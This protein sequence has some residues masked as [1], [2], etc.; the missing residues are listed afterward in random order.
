MANN[1]AGYLIGQSKNGVLSKLPLEYIELGS[2]DSTPNQREEIKAERDDNTRDLI[3]V[4]AGGRKSAIHFKT[5]PNLTL[6]EKIAFTTWFTSRESNTDERKIN[7]TFWND[8]ENAYKTGDFYRPNMKFPILR[9]EE[10]T[11][12]I[13]YD[14]LEIDLI[15]Y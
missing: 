15:E 5:R 10:S 6:D 7:L 11:N 4:T 8:E 12:N 14:S 13:I 2:Y 9:I 1:F 3:R